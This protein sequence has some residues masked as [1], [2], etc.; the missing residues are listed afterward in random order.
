MNADPNRQP[1]D[2]NEPRDFSLWA[3]LGL[4]E[5]EPL[6]EGQSPPVDWTL[7][8]RLVHQELSE[9]A[10]RMTYGLVHAYPEWKSAHA[11]ILVEEFKA[12]RAG[13]SSEDSA[14]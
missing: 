1:D 9:Q 4:T 5:P 12:G 13:E 6:A 2:A 3:E 11:Q 8:R 14:S 10:A 7:L